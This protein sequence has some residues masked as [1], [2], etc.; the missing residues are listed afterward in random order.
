MK[1]IAPWTVNMLFHKLIDNKNICNT[2]KIYVTI[3]DLSDEFIC[4]D[5]LFNPGLL[6]KPLKQV[7]LVRMHNTLNNTFKYKRMT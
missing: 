5:L 1:A 7:T 6:N 4:S 3:T 2:I